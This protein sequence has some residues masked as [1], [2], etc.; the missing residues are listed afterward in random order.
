[1]HRFRLRGIML[2]QPTSPPLFSM[3][4]AVVQIRASY[5]NAKSPVQRPA[6]EAATKSLALPCRRRKE[7]IV[8]PS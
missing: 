5:S 6:W 8:A 3:R 1:M 4:L 7:G 2:D